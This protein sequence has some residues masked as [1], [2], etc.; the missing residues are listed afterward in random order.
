[1]RRDGGDIFCHPL[2]ERRIVRLMQ[3]FKPVDGQI[4]LLTQRDTGAPFRPAVSAFTALVQ[5]STKHAYHHA[6]LLHLLSLNINS[7]I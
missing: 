7:D 5:H 3:Q 4:R 6:A 2:C 1:M